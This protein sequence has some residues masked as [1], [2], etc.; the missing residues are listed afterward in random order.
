MNLAQ[1][2]LPIVRTWWRWH[3]ARFGAGHLYSIFVSDQATGIGLLHRATIL[4]RM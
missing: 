1:L 4:A 3:G 2:C